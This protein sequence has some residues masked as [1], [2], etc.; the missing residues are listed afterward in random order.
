M[1]KKDVIQFQ[2]LGANAIVFQFHI[3]TKGTI[4][5]QAVPRKNG[6]WLQNCV[7]SPTCE[8]RPRTQ[9]TIQELLNPTNKK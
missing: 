1:R 8:Q 2:K 7:S 6:V 5:Q 3:E 4:L 9:I